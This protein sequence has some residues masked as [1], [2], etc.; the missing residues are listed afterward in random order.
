GGSA[1]RG[2]ARGWGA[3][4]DVEGRRGVGRDRG[5]DPVRGRVEGDP[6][7]GGEVA[8]GVR[9]RGQGAPG[10]GRARAVPR[11]DVLQHARP[12]AA[13]GGAEVEVDLAETV[14]IADAERLAGCR[15][16]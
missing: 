8:G 4:A 10:R 1:Q 2:G 13:G 9:E 6:T 14:R 16:G 11:R 15:E 7:G 12:A 5:G 3:D